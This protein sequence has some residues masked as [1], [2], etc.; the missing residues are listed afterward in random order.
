MYGGPRFTNMPRMLMK[1]DGSE[2]SEDEKR[3]FMMQQNS[4]V[5]P[6]MR[7]LP[8]EMV[9]R[10]HQPQQMQPP[11]TGI[12]AILFKT[13]AY[14]IVSFYCLCQ[15]L[16][17]LWRLMMTR[18]LVIIYLAD[19]SKAPKESPAGPA[20]QRQKSAPAPKASGSST[21]KQPSK[22]G[23]HSSDHFKLCTLSLFTM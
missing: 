15:W 1:M 12:Q 3:Q 23:I 21:S 22:E 16:L 18:I 9:A 20:L 13:S 8:P 7:P 4:S 10:M 19:N 6:G 2:M 5:R 17:H 14:T 11:L